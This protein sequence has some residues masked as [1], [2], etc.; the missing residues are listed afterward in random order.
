MEEDMTAVIIP[1]PNKR[2]RRPRPLISKAQAMMRIAARR[3]EDVPELEAI[4]VDIRQVFEE[5]GWTAS[6]HKPS[7]P[8]A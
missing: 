4:C 3:K 1:F 7:G 2:V 8:A 6:P 5:I